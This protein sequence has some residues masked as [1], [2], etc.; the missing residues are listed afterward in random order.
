MNRTQTILVGLLLLQLVLILIFRSPMAGAGP[1]SESRALLPELE[2]FTASKIEFL[3][4]DGKTAVLTRNED[5]WVSEELDGFP[6]DATKIDELLDKLGEIKVRRPVVA[7][8][9]YHKAFKVTEDD[10]ESRVRVWDDAADEPRIDLIVGTSPNYRSVHVRRLGEDQVYEIRGLASYELR[11]DAASWIDKMLVDV[12]ENAVS[13]LILSNAQGSFELA[14]NE[15]AGWVLRSPER[16]QDSPIDAEKVESLLGTAASIRIADTAGPVEDEAAVAAEAVATLTLRLM[17]GAV[18]DAQGD[19]IIVRLGEPL[20]DKDSQRKIYRAGFGY[21]GTI[22]DSSID[23]LLDQSADDLID[24][25]PD[26]ASIES[27]DEPIES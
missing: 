21:A 11:A 3:G 22:W 12:P 24:L 27:T 7:S 13:G 9:R 5:G 17:P 4:A 20:P 23:D 18:P 19:E 1:Q 6:A 8:T 10:Y 25:T 16:L 26:D 2:A 15:Q 14:R